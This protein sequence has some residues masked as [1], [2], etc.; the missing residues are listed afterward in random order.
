MS[1]KVF[2]S[3]YCEVLFQRYLMSYCSGLNVAVRKELGRQ[4]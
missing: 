3:S 4:E 1:F 2:F